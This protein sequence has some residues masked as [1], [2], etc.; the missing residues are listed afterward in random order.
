M[1]ENQDHPC[2]SYSMLPIKGFGL[3]VDTSALGGDLPSG[4]WNKSSKTT[5]GSNFPMA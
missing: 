5:D 2:R 3:A 1:P 4:D